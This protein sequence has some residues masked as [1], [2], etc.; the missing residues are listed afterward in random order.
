M[1]VDE[2]S[3]TSTNLDAVSQEQSEEQ[4]P[5]QLEE[6]EVVEEETGL[7]RQLGEEEGGFGELDERQLWSGETGGVVLVKVFLVERC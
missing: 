6:E 7:K 4:F 2:I 1:I 5:A 3:L